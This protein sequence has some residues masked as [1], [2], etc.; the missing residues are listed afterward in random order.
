MSEPVSIRT[1]N[2]GAMW[3][4]AL[5]TKFGSK[6]HEDLRDGNKAAIFP[7]FEAGA[8]AQFAL[9]H[10]KYA[11]MTLKDAIY[12]WS[13]HNSSA[14]YEDFLTKHASV[15]LNTVISKEFLEGPEGV[16]FAKAQAQWE[17]GK[18]YPM[19]DEQWKKAQDLAFGDLSQAGLPTP[20]VDIPL[21]IPAPSS[22]AT[23]N[24][25]SSSGTSL[26]KLIFK[27]LRR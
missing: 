25:G 14:A 7:T 10:D 19:T 17:A 15:S 3:P 4:N 6:T 20:T 18:P 8:A 23:A 2:P 1:K 11:G 26:L 5:A 12:K 16:R 9:W 13:G 24:P 22:P 27:L 21:P